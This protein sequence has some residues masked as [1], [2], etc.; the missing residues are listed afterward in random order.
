MHLPHIS[1]IHANFE[2]LEKTFELI[3]QHGSDQIL[4]LGDIVGYAAKLKRRD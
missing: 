1:E 2:A 3:D 4:C